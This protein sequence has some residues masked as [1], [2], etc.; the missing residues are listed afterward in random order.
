MHDARQRFLARPHIHPQRMRL[1][2]KARQW[3]TG[4]SDDGRGDY[5]E[6][7]CV[8]HFDDTWSLVSRR[9]RRS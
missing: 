7:V 3:D 5:C 2:S 6:P 4:V 9:S 1:R 8:M